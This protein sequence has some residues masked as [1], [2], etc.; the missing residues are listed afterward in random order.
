MLQYIE[1]NHKSKFKLDCVTIE[2]EKT[3]GL[4][5]VEISQTIFEI[6]ESPVCGKKRKRESLHKDYVPTEELE[7]EK[8]ELKLISSFDRTK[9]QQERFRSLSKSLYMRKRRKIK[10]EK[11]DNLERE[12]VQ[13]RERNTHLE[14][15]LKEFQEKL[16]EKLQE[17]NDN[18]TKD[19]S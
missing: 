11:R 16:E 4:F 13:L 12:N 6:E 9:E 8:E 2:Q 18:R 19:V 14:E 3:L 15:K 7:K 10:R 5:E 17:K 1:D